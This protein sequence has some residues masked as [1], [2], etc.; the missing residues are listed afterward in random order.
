MRFSAIFAFACIAAMTSP[1]FAAEKRLKKADVPAVVLAAVAAK[2]PKAT[3]TKFAQEDEAGKTVYE[4]QLKVGQA[5]T[6]LIVSADGKILTEEKTIARKELP[7]AVGKSLSTSLYTKAK[8][9]KIEMVTDSA[10]PDAPTYE[11][12]VT[13]QGKAHELVFTATGQLTKDETE[14]EDA[15]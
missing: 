15:D 9:I 12:L 10:K 8:L 4:V 5:K 1:A 3:L 7:A 2:Y 14:S 6:E 13:H 11:I